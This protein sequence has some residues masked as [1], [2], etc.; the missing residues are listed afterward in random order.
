VYPFMLLA[1][2]LAWPASVQMALGVLALVVLV[3]TTL[4]LTNW[5][6]WRADRAE[7]RRIRAER[8]CERTRSRR[9]RRIGA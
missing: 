7:L 9:A 4:L 8:K 2:A 3:G 6:E 1:D 5:N